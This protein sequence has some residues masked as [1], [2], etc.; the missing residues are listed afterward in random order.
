MNP[1]S[2]R[3]GNDDLTLLE[4]LST[5]RNIHKNKGKLALEIGNGQFIEVSKILIKNKFKIDRTI[6]DYNDNVRCII[7]TY[8]G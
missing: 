6:K 8:L 2:F 1:E 3:R 4:K 5:K 7:S